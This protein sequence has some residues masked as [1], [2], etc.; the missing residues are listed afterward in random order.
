MTWLVTGGA[1]YIGAHVVAALR[2]AGMGAVVLDDLSSGF[3][4]RLPAGVPCVVGSVLDGH[5]VEG[6]LRDHRVDGV[7]HLAAKKQVAESVGDP[8]FYYRENVEGL[9]VLLDAASRADVKRFVFSSSAA[10]YG[11]PPTEYITEETPCH[12][13]NPYGETKLAGEWLVRA[14][15]HATGAGYV[16]LRYFN[17]AGAGTPDLADRQATN[18]IPMVFEQ[19]ALGRRPVVFGADYPTPD[20]TCVRDFIHVSDLAAAHVVAARRLTADAGARLTLN[21]GR[22]R[23]VSV[24]EIITLIGEVTGRPV[25]PTVIERRVGDPARVVASVD[26]V[27]RKLGW[28]ARFGAR[29]MIS[30]AWTGWQRKYGEGAAPAGS[31]GPVSHAI[32]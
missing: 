16:S 24:R 22:G 20:G 11:S 26:S 31:E 29:E 2:E 1:G 10:V 28:S 9:R 19:L 21:V 12:P 18:L 8:L 15:A 27:L 3:A 13:V 32:R 23:G 7:I 14:V 5:L 30:S 25:E 4:D 6:V 17:V